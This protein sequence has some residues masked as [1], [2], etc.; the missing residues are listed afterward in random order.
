M[1]KKFFL[2]VIALIALLVFQ[3]KVVLPF[4]MDIV[5][6]DLFLEDTGDEPNSISTNTIMTDAAFNQCNFYIANE[7]FPEDS[8]TFS[9]K[10]L[11]AFGLG[12]FQYIVNSDLEIMHNNAAPSNRRYVCRIKYLNSDDTTGLSDIANWSID[13]IS[14]LDD[15]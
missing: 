6:S 13:G 12:G 9:E 3:I 4:V 5:A 8:L 15:I 10:P 14:G 11:N 1:N 7:L 2:I